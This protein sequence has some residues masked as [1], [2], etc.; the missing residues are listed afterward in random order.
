MLFNLIDG[1]LTGVIDTLEHGPAYALDAAVNGCPS[2]ERM[3]KSAADDFEAYRDD[4]E[5]EDEDDLTFL[6]GTPLYAEEE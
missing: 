2:A 6:E 5:S 3:L 4:Y 1:L